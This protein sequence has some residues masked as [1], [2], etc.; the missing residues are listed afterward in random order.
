MHRKQPDLEQPGNPVMPPGPRPANFNTD[1]DMT[2]A[3]HDRVQQQTP[4]SAADQAV[5]NQDVALEAGEEN[6]G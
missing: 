5:A 4:A 6:P 2:K 3:R 1:M